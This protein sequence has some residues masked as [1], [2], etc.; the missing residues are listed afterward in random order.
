MRNQEVKEFCLELVDLSFSCLSL[1]PFL[2]GPC[3]HCS[4]AMLPWLYISQGQGTMHMLLSSFPV[5][6]SLVDVC[7]PALFPKRKQES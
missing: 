3:I 7:T 4:G 2:P 6:I 5:H 1:L